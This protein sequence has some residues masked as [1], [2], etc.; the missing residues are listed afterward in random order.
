M[1][2]SE[3][4]SR[5]P[6]E[7]HIDNARRSIRDFL[8]QSGTV[9]V[10]LDD[11]PTGT[12]VIHDVDVV[13]HWT[14][15]ILQKKISEQDVFYISTNA[16]SLTEK[17]CRGT[18]CSLVKSLE[19][20][21]TNANKELSLVL[22]SDSTLRGHFDAEIE[23]VLKT[24]STKIDGILFVPAFFEG[25][26]FTFESEH[27]VLI[28]NRLVKA[29]NTEFAQD[30]SFG[31]S[32]S[33]LPKYIEEKTGERVRAS[34]VQRIL[35][36][37]IRE[38]GTERVSRI[39]RSL[40]QTTFVVADALNYADL[41]VL[42]LGLLDAERKGKKFLYRTAGS[43]VK[44]RAGI[45]DKELVETAKLAV[46]PKEVLVVVGSYVG[47]TTEQ[48]R[49]L[50]ENP[51]TVGIE[52]PVKEVLDSELSKKC[53]SESIRKTHKAVNEEKTPVIYTS[54]VPL[55]MKYDE[56]LHAGRSIMSILCCIVR[57]IATDSKVIISKGGIT[58]HMIAYKALSATSARVLGQILPGVPVWRLDRESIMPDG[59]Y[60]VF[61]GNV[62]DRNALEKVYSQLVRG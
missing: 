55:A 61:P 44:V 46:S 29:E 12:Q 59:L 39:L 37:D 38:G 3:L 42:V 30:P 47:K 43:F 52:L 23:S 7:L 48:L 51:S 16:R 58:S 62:G 22:R 41:E 56:F 53:V 11:D 15:E 31:F 5:V 32:S 57:A 8:E 60:V 36:N 6:P 1:D 19:R 10:V 25:G 4:L 49:V 40:N 18:L 54:R 45:E 24:S 35:L 28:G 13:L 34:E 9:L 17:E 20:A 2:F 33:Y 50:L 14:D 21:A 27:Y 26:R